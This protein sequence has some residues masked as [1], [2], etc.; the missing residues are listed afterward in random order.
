MTKIA[1][2]KV[3]ICLVPEQATWG[4]WQWCGWSRCDGSGLLW[5]WAV[6][7]LSAEAPK[8]RR[9]VKATHHFHQPQWYI[10][11]SSKQTWILL[12]PPHHD[13]V[14][15]TCAEVSDHL[16]IITL[17]FLRSGKE[18]GRR[19]KEVIH[20]GEKVG[21]TRSNWCYMSTKL[22]FLASVHSTKQW[23]AVKR[24]QWRCSLKKRNFNSESQSERGHLY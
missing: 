2:N 19:G 15:Q 22:H 24:W 6:K 16:L 20:L 13:Q 1:A 7:W 11:T 17:V 18:V 4:L 5:V 9:A 21:I 8:I 3:K 12:Y 14:G 10:A 23:L